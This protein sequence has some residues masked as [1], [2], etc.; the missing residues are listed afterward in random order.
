MMIIKVEGGSGIATP[1]IIRRPINGFVIHGSKINNM[2]WALFGR[3]WGWSKTSLCLG[4]HLNQL[5]RDRS[6]IGVGHS[7]GQYWLNDPSVELFDPAIA[8][9]LICRDVGVLQDIGFFPVINFPPHNVWGPG[10]VTL[11]EDA[12]SISHPV[13]GTGNYRIRSFKKLRQAIYTVNAKLPPN[14]PQYGL[15]DYNCTDFAIDLG[16]WCDIT[17]MSPVGVSTPWAFSDWLN[18]CPGL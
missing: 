15:L 13:T 18:A 10:V 14:S 6:I 11:G 8:N 3:H 7:W 9:L 17:T 5:G 1:V 2:I 4:A 16:L 12:G